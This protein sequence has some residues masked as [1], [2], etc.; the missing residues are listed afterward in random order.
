MND[1]AQRRNS[2]GL[3]CWASSRSDSA[4]MLT[5]K[6]ADPFEGP[7]LKI[8]RAKKHVADFR[9]AHKSLEG[10]NLIRVIPK[11]D[12]ETRHFRTTLELT[13]PLPGELRLTAADALYNLRSALDQ[14]VCRSAVLAGKSPKETYF[15]HGKDIEGFDAAL[16]AKCR[17]VPETARSA[18][19]SLQPYHG[20]NGYLFRVLHDLN[21]VDKHSDL[22]ALGMTVTRAEVRQGDGFQGFKPEGEL[23][24]RRKDQFERLGEVPAVVAMNQVH[25]QFKVSLT[26]TFRDVEIMKNEPAAHVLDSF[27]EHV[28]QA[29]DVIEKASGH[30]P[31]S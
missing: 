31:R 7:R 29:V 25:H 21:M 2:F 4:D 26:V 10:L 9:A 28:V 30:A 3:G 8:E 6:N 14:A 17:K 20:G 22:L 27:V 24:Q 18:I 12:P 15:P 16:A 19:A 23:W 1:A 5:H 11:I 13:E